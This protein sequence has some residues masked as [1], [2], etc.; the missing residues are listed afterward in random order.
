MTAAGE[1]GQST[2]IKSDT[3]CKTRYQLLQLRRMMCWSGKYKPWGIPDYCYMP[4]YRENPRRNASDTMVSMS[5]W[6]GCNNRVELSGTYQPHYMGQ[7]WNKGV[8][9]QLWWCLPA[10][11]Y[12]FSTWCIFWPIPPKVQVS[13]GPRS[14]AEYCIDGNLTNL[15]SFQNIPIGWFR[16]EREI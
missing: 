5:L 2:S 13:G 1:S 14:G 3:A 15:D 16:S 4:L 8:H 12:F 10:T 9:W 7:Q 6:I 11:A